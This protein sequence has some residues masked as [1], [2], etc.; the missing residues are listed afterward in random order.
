VTEPPD[1]EDWGFPEVDP[2]STDLPVDETAEAAP[3]EGPFDTG[4]DAWW[5]AQAAAQRAAS[6]H[7]PAVPPMVFEPSAPPEP[8]PLVEPEVLL[9]SAPPPPA[10]PRGFTEE[11]SAPAVPE[12]PS[13]PAVPEPP[14][15]PS[16]EPPL[17]PASAPPLPPTPPAPP[18][19]PTPLDS[20]WLPAELADGAPPTGPPAQAP[21]LPPMPPRINPAA[22]APPPKAAVPPRPPAPVPPPVPPG[23]PA[24]AAP[25][26]TVLPGLPD[27]APGSDHPTAAIPVPPPIA[28][29]PDTEFY[30]ALRSPVD[31]PPVGR[32]RAI[33][34]AALAVGAVAL[35]IVLLLVFRHEPK[36]SPT[37]T[38]PTASAQPTPTPTLSPTPRPTPRPSPTRV[39]AT[40]PPPTVAPVVAP[41]VP[42][43]VLNNSRIHNLAADAAKRFRAGGWPVPTTGNYSGGVIATTTVYYAPG[44]LGSAQRFARQFGIGRVLPRFAGLPGHGLTVVLTRDYRR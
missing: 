2:T 8:P 31:A 17:R 40:T 27:A 19:T 39:R 1:Q 22:A 38:L 12:P 25:T 34:G 32:R 23:P 29:P 37:L 15:V 44:Q 42:V 11:P 30:D 43:T 4:S 20:G 35:G 16:V 10:F 33:G 21:S 7:E 28:P 24:V 13:A 14:K 6:A 41:I 36:G 9:P 26:K 3:G 18:P 5:R